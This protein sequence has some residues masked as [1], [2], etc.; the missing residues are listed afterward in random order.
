MFPA[1]KTGKNQ[2]STRAFM[3]RGFGGYDELQYE[4]YARESGRSHM[5]VPLG[6]YLD[7]YEVEAA[8]TLQG[9]LYAMQS[10]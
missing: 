8:T 9:I 5:R 4:A 2:N 1:K 6:R 7:E 10:I 3:M